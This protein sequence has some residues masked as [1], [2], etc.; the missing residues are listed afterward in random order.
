MVETTEEKADGTEVLATMMEE[1]GE[2]FG[3]EGDEDFKGILNGTFNMEMLGGMMS[4]LMATIG[5]MLEN[6]LGPMMAMA[7]PAIE[8]TNAQPEVAAQPT[9]GMENTATVE[10]TAGINDPS[11]S[12]LNGPQMGGGGSMG[13]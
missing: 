10:Q 6:L 2:L 8:A 13:G 7:N 4:S 11:Q 3:F 9:P 12:I 5:P 1:V